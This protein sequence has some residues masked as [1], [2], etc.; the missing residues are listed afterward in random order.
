MNRTALIIVAKDTLP[1][2]W[3]RVGEGKAKITSFRTVEL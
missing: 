1:W 3:G 2:N